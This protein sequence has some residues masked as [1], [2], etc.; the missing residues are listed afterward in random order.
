MKCSGE[1]EI[2]GAKVLRQEWVWS[3]KGQHGASVWSRGSDGVEKE[4]RSGTSGGQRAGLPNEVLDLQPLGSQLV[5]PS[6]LC[7]VPC[8]A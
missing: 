7:D 3:F 2:A 6:W 4:V 1:E 5:L 8:S